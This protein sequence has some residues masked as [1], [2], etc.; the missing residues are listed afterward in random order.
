MKIYGICSLRR[1]KRNFAVAVKTCW[2]Q[3]KRNYFLHLEDDWNFIKIVDFSIA[4]EKLFS[5]DDIVAV[6]L[7]RFDKKESPKT[8]LSPALWKTSAA[9]NIISK[10]VDN[11]NPEQQIKNLT[12]RNSSIWYP[13]DYPVVKDIG[14][15]WKIENHLPKHMLS[16][17]SYDIMLG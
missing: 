14:R 8:L 10:M 6:M 2:S 4:V 11:D 12:G 17:T 5:K 1:K 9:R 3:V 13:I 16:K 7:S 15:K